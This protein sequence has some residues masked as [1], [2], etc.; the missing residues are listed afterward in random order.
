MV[1]C[2]TRNLLR[3]EPLRSWEDA[4]VIGTLIS[5]GAGEIVLEAR[6][7]FEIRGRAPKS[8]KDVI[9]KLVAVALI[10]GQVRWRL[11]E[12]APE[13]GEGGRP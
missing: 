2:M 11:V 12:A 8:L 9:G 1:W 7:R 6:R 13:S 4:E 10:D 3:A 5:V